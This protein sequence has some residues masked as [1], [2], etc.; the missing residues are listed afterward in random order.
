[1]DNYKQKVSILYVGSLA[2]L[3]LAILSCT[4]Q[5]GKPGEI[6]ESTRGISSL[7]SNSIPAIP[8]A[9]PSQF[10]TATNSP[11]TPTPNPTRTTGNGGDLN[12]NNC[13]TSP[14]VMCMG[15]YDGDHGTKQLGNMR[16]V[17]LPMAGSS[18]NFGNKPQ[19]AINIVNKMN[20]YYVFEGHTHIKFNP[21][22]IQL[23]DGISP[24]ISDVRNPTYVAQNFGTTNG[25]FSFILVEGYCARTRSGS[26]CL[27]GYSSYLRIPKGDRFAFVVMDAD[28][29]LNRSIGGVV[30]AHEFGHMIGMQHTTN[31]NGGSITNNPTGVFP[32]I[33]LDLR[34][35]EGIYDFTTFV[36]G[37]NFNYEGDTTINNILYTTKNLMFYSAKPYDLFVNGKIGSNASISHVLG[38][39]YDT[40]LRE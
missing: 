38:S 5:V 34:S 9:T 23:E 2:V 24:T 26:G 3:L 14:G 12:P 8:T 19:A 27:L 28:Y 15:G 20:A 18:F 29:I 11:A 31:A 1:M 13:S 33:N 17:F 25:T 36:Y 37:G 16:I 22:N 21:D 7:G 39:Y 40:F 6:L 32:Y 4:P 35:E 30:A 10:P